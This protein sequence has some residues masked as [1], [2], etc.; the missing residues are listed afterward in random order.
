M[1]TSNQRANGVGGP[2]VG[3][4]ELAV[5]PSTPPAELSLEE[6][7]RKGRLMAIV[8]DSLS[9]LGA[10]G[11]GKEGIFRAPGAPSTGQTYG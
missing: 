4:V 2:V 1:S 11:W 3:A 8:L 10:V 7:Q 5:R 6:R 9:Q